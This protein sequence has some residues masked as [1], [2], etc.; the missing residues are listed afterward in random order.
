[1][2][3]LISA[4]VIIILGAWIMVA[5][6]RGEPPDIWPTHPSATNEPCWSETLGDD[7]GRHLG[8][9]FEVNDQLLQA[10]ARTRSSDKFVG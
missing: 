4:A 10:D 5:L 6:R 3:I 9:S 8:R 1:M 2:E 7:Q